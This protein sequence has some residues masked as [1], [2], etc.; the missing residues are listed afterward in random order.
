MQDFAPA[1]NCVSPGRHGL[2]IS[3]AR[4]SMSTTKTMTG[5]KS[6]GMAVML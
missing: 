1:A 6:D 2:A 5:T 4:I 3:A